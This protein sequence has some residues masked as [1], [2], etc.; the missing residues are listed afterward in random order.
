VDVG[1]G[2]VDAELH[3][4]RTPALELSLE[5]AVREHVDCI[6]SQLVDAGHG[7]RF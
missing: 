3:A 5:R 7:A 6:A 2:R 4:K 1:S